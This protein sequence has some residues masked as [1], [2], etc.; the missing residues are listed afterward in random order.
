MAC[1]RLSSIR[2]ALVEG[3]DWGLITPSRLRQWAGV[4]R[5]LRARDLSRYPPAKRQTLML[6]F[7]SVRAEEVTDA[8]VEMFDALVGRV[9][10]RADDELTD[11]KGDRD[12][13]AEACVRGPGLTSRRVAGLLELR[14]AGP[15]RLH[16]V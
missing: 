16:L 11:V 12:K 7:L 8:I 6:A 3:I 9:F 10:S 13:V 2:E 5:R 14:A 15:I 4:V 1:Q